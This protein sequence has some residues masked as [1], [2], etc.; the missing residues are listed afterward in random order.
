M[1]TF[2]E[3][4]KENDLGEGE[5]KTVQANGKAIA[6]YKKGGAFYALDNTCL[7]AGGPLGEGTLDG[8]L[9][10]CPLH[11][12][13]YHLKTGACETVPGMEVAVYKVKTENGKVFV[14]V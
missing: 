8:E 3:V 6:L 11:G 1:G 10:T 2:V 14:E 7:H 4:A 9:V 5:G 12:W 13:Q